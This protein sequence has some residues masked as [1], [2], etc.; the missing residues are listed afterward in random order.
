MIKLEIISKFIPEKLKK[1]ILL[2]PIRKIFTGNQNEPWFTR[3][4]IKIIN[5]LLKNEF[6]GFES[7]SGVSTIWLAERIKYLISIEH[8]INWFYI[9]SNK[10]KKKKLKNIDYKLITGNDDQ[11][12]NYINNFPNSYFDIVIVD[13]KDREKCIKNSIEKIKP[14]GIMVLDN[15]DR[16]Q[17]DEAKQL[18]EKWK[19]IET[20]N[21]LWK[22]TI[23]IKKY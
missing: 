21:S 17:L 12:A 11:Y 23:Y 15:S 14:K 1:L 10:I 19:K 20:S 13:G 6:I 9:I 5:N 3:D 2:T 7:G 18:L 16:K 4:S 22:T 8:D